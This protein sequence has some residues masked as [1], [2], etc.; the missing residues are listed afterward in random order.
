MICIVH[1]HIMSEGS[2]VV[3]K[4]WHKGRHIWISPLSNEKIKRT[5]T[6]RFLSERRKR[7][8]DSEK[9]A[10]CKMLSKVKI[11]EMPNF[12]R[13]P[14]KD[15]RNVWE[16]QSVWWPLHCWAQ[17][18]SCTS[19]Y[20]FSLC[21]SSWNPGMSLTLRMS[22]LSLSLSRA[23]PRRWRFGKIK[24]LFKL[25]LSWI[26][27]QHISWNHI[28][29]TYVSNINKIIM[30]PGVKQHLPVL[31]HSGHLLQAL[32]HLQPA[33]GHE[34]G[35]AH[36]P[37]QHPHHLSLHQGGEPC[38][39]PPRCPPWTEAWCSWPGKL[40]QVEHHF[41]HIVMNTRNV[42]EIIT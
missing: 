42:M 3:W 28:P 27:H 25:F 37:C 1:L 36:D 13:A 41:R 39:L 19:K 14:L 16:Q 20:Y 34:G 32:G 11:F 23:M 29:W 12:Q 33:G 10:S 9:H 15:L 18:V 24:E 6:V 38:S 30:N 35:D 4:D 21:H 22:D 31:A 40:S 26:S 5:R 8:Y 17:K 2:T 7:F